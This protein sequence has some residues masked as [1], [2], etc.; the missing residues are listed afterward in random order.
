[1]P[2]PRF[3]PLT[4]VGEFRLM[5]YPK[6]YQTSLEFYRD[7]LGFPITY[8]WDRAKSKGVMFDTGS[9]TIELLWDD[10][11]KQPEGCDVSLEVKDVWKL[12]KSL[13]GKARLVHGIQDNPWGD[14]SF[15]IK[16][17]SGFDIIFFTKNK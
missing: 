15:C 10:D 8:Q 9:A 6:K 16:D 1:M 5:L 4:K 11:Q 12:A 2:K 14:T 17:P 7:V 3:N 13:H